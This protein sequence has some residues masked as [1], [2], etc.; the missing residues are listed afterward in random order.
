[1]GKMKRN[2]LFDGEKWRKENK[3][4][5]KLLNLPLAVNVALRGYVC[6]DICQRIF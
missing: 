5:D 2:I 6:S 1:M 4:T 3:F